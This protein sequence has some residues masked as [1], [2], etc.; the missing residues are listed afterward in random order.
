MASKNGKNAKS[1][2]RDLRSLDYMVPLVEVCPPDV[3][4]Q[5]MSKTVEDAMNGDARAR[6]FLARQLMGKPPAFWEMLLGP[7]NEIDGMIK[8]F[9]KDLS[10]HL[11]ISTMSQAERMI[12][13]FQVFQA[14]KEENG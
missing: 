5:I 3:W 2:G 8:R 13:G 4:K 11:N 9:G 14:D 1:G 6:D 7:G 10:D 12:R